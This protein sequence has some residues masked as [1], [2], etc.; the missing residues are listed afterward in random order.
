MHKTWWKESVVYQ[1]Y[2][3]SFADSDGDGIG[4]LRGIT[5]KLVYL[6]QLG[7]DVVWLSPVY[8]SPND[9]MGYDISDYQ[10][11][12]DEFG[13]MADWDEMLDEMHKRGIRLLMDLVVNHTSDEHPW[14]VESRKSKDNPYRDFYI[15]RPGKDGAEPNNWASS[16]SGSAWE[17]DETTGEYF[18]HLFSKKQPDLNWENPKVRAAIYD[19]MHWW[20]KK[21]IDG[22]RMDVINMISKVPGL[23]D[24][25]ALTNDRYQ[26]A[27]QYVMHGPRLMEFL[28][29]MKQEVLSK[30]DIFTVGEMPMVTTEHA[31]DIT[32]TEHGH[33]SMLFQFEHM[34]I[35]IDFNSALGKWKYQP[36]AL[37]DLKRVMTVWQKDLEDKGGTASICPTMISRARS[38]ASATTVSTGPSRPR[39][40]PPSC[41]CCKAR[42]M[43][44][45]AKRSA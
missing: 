9:D 24:A 36:L 17:Y 30:Y 16:F 20:L 31:I 26:F 6:K 29:E 28:Q 2:P 44:T 19:M 32:H 22:F 41:T 12:M 25:P 42:P 38:R 39:C 1:I 13:T 5:Q 8:K 21:G 11:I 45:R 7:V 4:D 43:S 37:L 23:P 3:R 27:G 35:D 40:S 14:F 10:A 18:L 33:L 34:G 15:W